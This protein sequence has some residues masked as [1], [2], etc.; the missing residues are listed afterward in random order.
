MKAKKKPLTKKD[1]IDKGMTPKSE[2]KD[3]K[4]DK[5]RGIKENSKKDL[6]M[7]SKGMQNLKAAMMGMK[8]GKR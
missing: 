5:K 8:R 6:N 4:M 1:A 3:T 7:D 2:A